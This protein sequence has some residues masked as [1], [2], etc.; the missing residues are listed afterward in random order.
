MTWKYIAGFF[1][2]EGSVSHNGKGFRVTLP[3]TNRKV[4]ESIQNFADSGYVIEITKRKAHWK[5]SWVYYIAKQKEVFMF[6]QHIAP[7]LIVKQR[8]VIEALQRL[9]V[10]LSEQNKRILLRQTRERKARALR[11]RGLPY[12]HIG[13]ALG[14]DWGYARRLT[15]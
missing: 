3:Q 8:V 9:T 4:L 14:I 6:L 12:R 11:K 1:D 15:L 10:I 13:E 7:Y 2:G 5:D